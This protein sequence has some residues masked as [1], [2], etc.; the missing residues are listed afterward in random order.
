MPAIQVSNIMSVSIR[1]LWSRPG[2]ET[3]WF[4]RKV[5]KDLAAAVGKTWLQFSLGTKDPAQ[6]A[7][8]ITAHVTAQDRE[9]SALRG[10][11]T[12]STADQ[13]RLL[14][15]R[16]GIDPS[17][18]EGTSD[19]TLWAFQDLI[20]SQLP[21]SVKEDETIRHGRQLDQHLSPVHRAALR[22]VQG[23]KPF[24]LSECMEQYIGARPATEKDARLVF[25]YLQTFL[26]T[27]RPGVAL[28]RDLSKIR[29]G[30][31][32]DFVE[33]LRNPEAS[34]RQ[35]STTTVERYITTL[36]AAFARAIRENELGIENPFLRVEIKDL[37]KDVQDRETFTA[38]QYRHLYAALDQ[39][40]ETKGLDPLRCILTLVAETGARLAEVVGLA[41]AD[42]DLTG[43][44]PSLR[45]AENPWRS[46][47]TP[48]SARHIPLSPRA[49]EAAKV[50]LRLRGA[51]VELFPGRAGKTDSVSATLVKWVRDR[52]GL[53]GSRLGNHSLR[54]G[55]KDRLRAV[56]CPDSI[57]DQILGH[58]APSVG[59]TYGTGYPLTVLAEW[60][61]RAL[62]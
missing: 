27:Q 34:G 31:V 6:A 14:L 21:R 57:Q 59:A 32:N 40:A 47:K 23:R 26:K 3:L 22:M 18:L 60:L 62:P 5:P 7:R 11:S 25:G 10:A 51:A 55:M 38:D 8:L 41:A 58:A 53:K 54:H 44:M 39:W 45:I 17:D 16:N 15:L 4:K 37:G 35:V 19:G 61:T 28:D 52:E 9:W 46:L 56:Q 2:T 48:G 49:V 50:A 20:E 13:A 36:R 29:R 33:W 12:A 30:D 42:L 24:T 1:Y 43:P